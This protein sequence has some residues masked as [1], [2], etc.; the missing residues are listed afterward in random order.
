MKPERES[1]QVEVLDRLL[2]RGAVL[3]ADLGGALALL[4]QH[5]AKFA[6]NVTL[7]LAAALFGGYLLHMVPDRIF[8]RT[9]ELFAALPA[10]VMATFLLAFMILLYKTAT[11]GFV[12]FIYFQF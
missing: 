5:F 7:P 4:G 3:N 8:N 12:P 2:D 6:P 1:S 9:R 11:A 10:P